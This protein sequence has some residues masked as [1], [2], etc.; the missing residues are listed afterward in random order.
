[1]ELYLDAYAIL[2][3]MFAPEYDGKFS[4]R[5]EKAVQW[6]DLEDLLILVT[7]LLKKNTHFLF[8]PS[9]SPAPFMPW[10]PPSSQYSSR[11]P[12]SSCCRTRLVCCLDGSAFIPPW[13]LQR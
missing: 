12:S 2:R 9:L 6:R 4:L 7:S 13:T 8:G 11:C 10:I 3:R 1:M 5:P